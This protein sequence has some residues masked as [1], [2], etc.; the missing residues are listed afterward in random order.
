MFKIILRCY[1]SSKMV[2]VL[3]VAEKNDAAKSLA[4]VM[5]QGRYRKREG[6]SR[7]N[8][9][10]EFDY[11]LLNQNAAMTM[12]SVSGHLLELNF[13]GHYSKWNSCS[14]SALF[15][16][17]VTKYC[18]EKFLEIKRTLEREVRGCQILVIWTDCDR[19]GENIGFEVIQVCQQVKANIRVY[20][21]RFSEITPQAVHR[22]VNNLVEPDK[23]VS[24]AV[25]VRSE[26][27]L[28]IGA[29]FTRFQT[30]RLQKVFPE[31][32]ADKLIS[33]GSCQFP[34]LGF[35]VERY[36]Q[37]QA[38]IP[39][40]FWKLKVSHQKEDEVKAEFT[41]KRVRLFDYLA[42][43]VLYE[44][45]IENP[46]A[47]VVDVRSKSKSKWRPVA[48]DT[49]EMEKLASRKLRINAKEAMKIAEK[50]YTSGFIS[51]PRTETNM[52]PKDLDMQGLIQEQTRDPHWG[53]FAQGVLNSGPQPRNGNKTDNAHPPIHP[54]KYTATL[55]GNEQKL[56]EFIVRHFLA[57]CSQ[58][59]QGFET[60][61]EIDIAEERFTAQGLMIVA[62]NYLDVYPYEKWNAKMNPG[63]TS[64][65]PL[66]SEADLIALMEKH[67]I[68]TDATHAEHIETI[69]NRSYVGVRPDGRFVPGHLG[70]GLV[71]GYDE[72]GYAM[73]KPH[74]RAELESDL[75]LICEGRKN[76]DVVLQDQVRKY[77]EVFLEATR[78]AVKLDDALAQYL[79]QANPVNQSDVEVTGPAPVCPCPQ[80]G[81][82]M[83]LRTKKDGKGFFIGCVAYPQ[84]R[85]VIWLPDSVL[86]AS[87]QDAVCDKCT[88]GPV[89]MV[90]FKF[91]RGSVPPMIPLDYVGC[92]GGCDEMLKQSL[93]LPTFPQRPAHN[94]GQRNAA[95]NIPHTNNAAPVR[96]QST[97]TNSNNTS[98]FDL[99]ASRP[100][101]TSNHANRSVPR[102]PRGD[103][104]RVPL[105][106]MNSVN[107][108]G[109]NS[110]DSGAGG[111]AIVCNCGTDAILLTVKK[112]G[113][114]KGRQFYKCQKPTGSGCSFFL[115]QDESGGKNNSSA[116]NSSQRPVGVANPRHVN[117]PSG[118][119]RLPSTDIPQC[120]CSQPAKSLT[121]QKDGPNKGRQFYTCSQPPD[122]RCRFFQWA[123]EN[124]GPTT[125]GNTG[126]PQA[127]NG[128]RKRNASA[129]DA[130]PQR[131]KKSC[132]LCGQIG[133][134]KRTCPHKDTG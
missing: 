65:P 62:R 5:S 94:T 72:M 63:E 115:W 80:C 10:Y 19:E 39:E 123:D 51:Y 90:K 86:E 56:Y 122:Q 57:C 68:G 11:H 91:R 42:C 27:D 111:S 99:P 88:P 61:V 46:V 30:M 23:N 113:P 95:G 124:T 116:N 17:P 43:L 6:L 16:L 66:L 110:G 101:V 26:L 53:E 74:L 96:R 130:A 22:A 4:D 37:V 87:A 103:A 125:G 77:K 112:E 105:T 107:V 44:Q 2:R 78:Q 73:S 38:F 132:S 35:V 52:F 129:Q 134:T 82:Q 127:G 3:N 14:P 71:E 100:S 108:G 36:K 93:D 13:A 83:V 60:T 98:F 79:G 20:R 45:C 18:P 59:A 54:I 117:I 126:W 64:P 28:R 76:K 48:L 8:K 92:I 109:L 50:L 69:K 120:G 40:P 31:V 131:K 81:S 75:K 121:V 70:M 7:F 34:T 128:G 29:S 25:D 104:S 89:H 85:N 49:V 119:N 106:N 15:E 133:H 114:N 24:D 97:T 102:L 1:C 118:N 9:L 41:W 32:L 67:G 55:Q 12:T 21:A 33:Y 47:T 58:D 84:C